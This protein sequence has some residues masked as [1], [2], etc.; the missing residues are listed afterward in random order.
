MFSTLKK[1]A[2][3]GF[4]ALFLVLAGCAAA[5]YV[6]GYNPP[7]VVDDPNT[8]EDE[9]NPAQPTSSPIQW[10]FTILGSVFSWEG[11]GAAGGI[12][13]AIRW[14]YIEARKRKM[15]AMFK[16]VVVG[17]KAAVDAAQGAPLDKAKL[18]ASIAG[19][20][21]VFTNRDVFD[22]VVDSIK[23]AYDAEKT[24]TKIV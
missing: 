11:A 9:T 16:A 14:A 5:D 23:K 6:F 7:A 22:K 1:I 12:A 15:D 19:A 24:E 10:L 2:L 17:I 18:Y 8:P 4:A 13:G 21:D 20:A 3:F